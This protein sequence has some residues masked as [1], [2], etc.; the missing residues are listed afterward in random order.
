[1]DPRARSLWSDAVAA[2]VR[3]ERAAAN[4]TQTQL[5][6]GAG[7]SRS[8][9]IRIEKGTHVADVTELSKLCGVLGIPLS[10]FF[11]RVEQRFVRETL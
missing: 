8:T 6:K 3:A 2:Q 10:Q 11:A 7:L 1:M 4:L 9:Y 5:F